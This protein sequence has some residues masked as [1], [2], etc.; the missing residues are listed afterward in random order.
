M[1]KF[2]PIPE[3]PS[4][5]NLQKIKED[6]TKTLAAF[7]DILDD[8]PLISSDVPKFPGDDHWKDFKGEFS[9]AQTGRCG[10][11]ELN[12]V[13]SSHGDVE[14]YRPKGR[15]LTLDM[16]N[17]GKEKDNL[18]NVIGRKAILPESRCYTGYWWLAYKW[19]NYLLACSICNRTWKGNY[20]PVEGET[21]I[22]IR[23][24]PDCEN[25]E[26]PLLLNPFLD[27]PNPHIKFDLD[28][29]IRA[30]TERGAATI[31]TVG[32]WRPSLITK[33]AKILQTI[34]RSIVCVLRNSGSGEAAIEAAKTILELGA[35]DASQFPGVVRNYFERRAEMKWAMLE[36]LIMG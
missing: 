23:P 6:K 29:N 19:S 4:F 25:N 33:R 30:I 18:V 36:A 26:T 11:C 24:I 14:H 20:F 9:E 27:D 12:A 16:E 13:G 10:Y 31:A 28:G 3:P 8:T 17:Q 7:D 5:T 15:I 22:N 21:N 1:L 32:L 34:D 2:T 35:D